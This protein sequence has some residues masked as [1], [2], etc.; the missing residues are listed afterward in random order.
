MNHLFHPF[1]SKQREQRA[2]ITKQAQHILFLEA[3][4]TLLQEQYDA[5]LERYEKLEVERDSL[6]SQLNDT[7]T[8]ISAIA[9]KHQEESDALKAQVTQLQADLKKAKYHGK[10]KPATAETGTQTH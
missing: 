3:R 5:L 1:L 8:L 10:K 7:H 4:A 2:E 9:H 6:Q